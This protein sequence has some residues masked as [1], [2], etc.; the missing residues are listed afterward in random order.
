M[1]EFGGRNELFYVLFC[2]LYF[3][4]RLRTNDGEL[5][6]VDAEFDVPLEALRVIWMTAV[7]ELKL[8]VLANVEVVQAN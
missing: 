2:H 5:A 1:D 8:V 4:C 3:A 7:R 6:L